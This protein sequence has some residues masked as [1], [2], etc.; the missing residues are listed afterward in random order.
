VA[1][2]IVLFNVDLAICRN[3]HSQP[4]VCPGGVCTSQLAIVHGY[5]RAWVV[6]SRI[7]QSFVVATSLM[8][9]GILDIRLL[10]YTLSDSIHALF[11]LFSNFLQS[12]I[13]QHTPLR[14]L[15]FNCHAHLS[16]EHSPEVS[17]SNPSS[18]PTME[19]GHHSLVVHPNINDPNV[20]VF[21]RLV[22]R[23]YHL[24]HN[25]DI[26]QIRPLSDCSCNIHSLLLPHHCVP[27]LPGKHASNMLLHTLHC[28][29]TL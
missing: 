29:R 24:S 15:S 20:F 28:W 13:P 14:N 25:I 4:K 21:Y 10:A 17:H 8:K 2:A 1:F 3:P 9:F 27:H 19:I 12:I 18:T 6:A 26:V 11:D 23:L 16:L 5:L 7:A 22:P